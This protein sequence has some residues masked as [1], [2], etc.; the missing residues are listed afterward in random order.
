MKL[1]SIVSLLFLTV[2]LNAGESARVLH[3]IDGETLRI[4]KVK[5]NKEETIRLLGIKA[6]PSTWNAVTEES[7]GGPYRDH[8]IECYKGKM[9]KD[10]LKSQAKRYDEVSLE[11][12]PN[13]TGE[14]GNNSQ[15]LVY[16]ANGV[17]LNEEILRAGYATPKVL[18]SQL[19]DEYK[20]RFIRANKEAMQN[21]NGLYGISNER[22][23]RI[24]D[25]EDEPAETSFNLTAVKADALITV[26]KKK[27][28]KEIKLKLPGDTTAQKWR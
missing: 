18:Q 12:V 23:R 15:A 11:Y 27:P 26:G 13:D 1:I 4:V 10:Y 6:P 21:K 7:K 28:I 19:K 16:L 5:D 14:N 9:S 24:V 17:L 20:E 3:V 2:N 8:H 25:K 22:I